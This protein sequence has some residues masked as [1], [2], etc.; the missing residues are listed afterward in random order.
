MNNVLK[1]LSNWT[2]LLSL[3]TQVE[4]AISALK[5]GNQVS[6]PAI[7]VTIGGARYDV[8]VTVQQH[9]GS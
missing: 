5:G 7:V 8:T 6:A 4:L 3:Y 2:N 9:V 1:F